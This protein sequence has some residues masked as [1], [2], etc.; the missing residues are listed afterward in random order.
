MVVPKR[1][2]LLTLV[3]G[4]FALTA[5]LN[6]ER[7]YPGPAANVL[8]P[9]DSTH[10]TAIGEQAPDFSLPNLAGANVAL[11]SLRGRPV[12]LYFWATWCHYCLEAM[13]ELEAVRAEYKEA[14][15]EVL[16]VNILENPEKVR[17]HVRR[18]NLSLPILLDL[19]ALVTQSYVVRATPTYFLI[20]HE[21]ILRDV[22]VGS[23]DPGVLQGRLQSILQSP[24]EETA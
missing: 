6:W 3:A 11:S 20:D 10:R 14:G 19:E 16:A 24:Q 8:A 13:P 4:I 7:S 9:A 21:G 12:V 18:H 5:W 22:I 1:V 15:L 2:L 17:A 23:P